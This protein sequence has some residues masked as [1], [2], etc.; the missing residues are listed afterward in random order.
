MS[1]TQIAILAGGVFLSICLGLSNL[2][3][4]QI[5]GF[6]NFESPLARG[7]AVTQDGQRLLAIN[8]PARRLSVYSL[9]EPDQPK[10][11][12]EIPVG[13][14]PVSVAIHH[15][16]EAWV[17][18][19][20]SNSISV[21]DLERGIVVETISVGERPGDIV[22]AGE[23]LRAFA[24]S[25]NRQRVE[26]LDATTRS[27]IQTIPIVGAD[28]RTLT[29]SRDGKTVWVAIYRSGNGT[30]IVPFDKA[31]PPPTPNNPDLPPA[32]QQG[33][34]VDSRAAFQ[35]GEIDFELADK[36][37]FAID[38]NNLKVIQAFPSIGT[39]I[40][41]LAEHP[42]NGDIWVTNM[43]SHNQVRFEPELKGRFME[44]RVTRISLKNPDDAHTIQLNPTENTKARERKQALA[45][46]IAQP[47]DIIFTPDGN[48]SFVTSLGTDRIAKLN[49][50]GKVISRIDLLPEYIDTTEPR[51]KRGPRSLVLSPQKSHLFVLNGL[52][53]SI[54]VIDLSTETVV[55]EIEMH[56]PTPDFI[57]EG[58]GYLFDAKLSAHGTVS[59]ASCHIDGDRD[60]LAWDLGDPN[61]QLF[62]NG[63]STPLHPMKGPLVTQTLK[64]LAG[65]RIFH[66]RADRPGLASFNDTFETLLGGEVLD[67]DDLATFVDYMKSIHFGP[68]PSHLPEKFTADVVH[69]GEE[70]FTTRDSVGRDGN[71]EFRCIDCHT[72]PSGSGG[73]GFTGTIGQSTKVAQLRGLAERSPTAWGERVN[74]F[75]YGPD[76]SHGSLVEFLGNDHR[77]ASI[78]V[79]DR[80]ALE[81]Y[82]FLFPNEIPF[83][84]GRSCTIDSQNCDQETRRR[85]LEEMIAQAEAGR[86]EL[87]ACGMLGE[88]KVMFEYQPAVHRFVDRAIDA[89][90]AGL[91]SILSRVSNDRGIL[92]FYCLPLAKND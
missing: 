1:R 87:V 9:T 43:E 19:Q 41:N 68:S 29:A 56:D 57:R 82:L 47:T 62:R 59:C 31:P 10:L 73:S 91:Q 54:S 30:T 42:T 53:N 49:H 64:G 17:V 39:S 84:V 28:P 86:C 50:D 11:E 4:G 74:G 37:L 22:F 67:D 36:D 66:W 61:G 51:V 70:I 92:S 80:K 18:N 60:G 25:M 16:S 6:I 65:E 24:T 55:N 5:G 77:F 21:V 27:H 26:V 85:Q 2:A 78:S 44:N 75:G 63:S 58:R 40:F 3:T 38:A 46:A 34:I 69:L 79:H 32:P 45:E 12:N 83:A 89:E 52:S 20:V 7:L 48:A 81:S 71:N 15:N 72:K 76:G 13:I 33:V 88:Q 8:K 35:R 90:Y 14:D 23:P